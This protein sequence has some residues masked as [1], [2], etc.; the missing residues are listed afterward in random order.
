MEVEAAPALETRDWG[1]P[2]RRQMVGGCREQ[3]G[4][5]WYE[6]AGTASISQAR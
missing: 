1:L 6:A 3:R 4:S 5:E 2:T